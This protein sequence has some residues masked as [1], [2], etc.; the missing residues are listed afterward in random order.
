MNR[1]KITLRHNS[2]S[3]IHAEVAKWSVYN[4][5]S[6]AGNSSAER[7]VEEKS[8]SGYSSAEKVISRDCFSNFY[9]FL[10]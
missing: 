7:E 4:L 2:H 6:I 9:S 3:L 8:W 1:E 10:M 5:R